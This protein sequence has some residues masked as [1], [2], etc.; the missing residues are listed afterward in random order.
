MGLETLRPSGFIKKAANPDFSERELR[1]LVAPFSG[2]QPAV[3]GGSSKAMPSSGSGGG[4]V[5]GNCCEKLLLGLEPH[6]PSAES[7]V[8]GRCAQKSHQ[9][10][11]LQNYQQDA[12][13]KRLSHSDAGLPC[14]ELTPVP[15]GSAWAR[16]GPARE[17]P[18]ILLFQEKKEKQFKPH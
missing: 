15:T 4:L 2:Y 14:R 9:D 3:S 17:I 5:G 10:L 6:L 16:A 11:L 8:V 13:S 12:F 7:L 1:K 18:R